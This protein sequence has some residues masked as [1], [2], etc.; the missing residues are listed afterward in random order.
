MPRLLTQILYYLD[1]FCPHKDSRPV[2]LCSVIQSQ[3][4]YTALCIW[5][6]PYQTFDLQYPFNLP[7]RSGLCLVWTLTR[8]ALVCLRHS[9]LP[10]D[11]A[12]PPH[13]KIWTFPFPRIRTSRE[14]DADGKLD[15]NFEKTL[16][17]SLLARRKLHSKLAICPSSAPLAHPLS[18]A[19]LYSSQHR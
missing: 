2:V 4:S 18:L 14:A 6:R 9:S 19:H 12:S 5:P 15:F 7:R 3:S 16:R 8:L 13:G 1:R 10:A 11:D 17:G